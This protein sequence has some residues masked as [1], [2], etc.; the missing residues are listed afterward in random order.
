MK[1]LRALKT[2]G[3]LTFVSLL[4][5]FSSAP[6]IHASEGVVR[7]E[8]MF[9]LKLELNGAFL[10]D[11]DGFLWIGSVS[12]LFR[13][14]GYELK[15]YKAGPDSLSGNWIMSVAE[16]KDGVIWI[17][18]KGGGVTGY[19]KKT[20]IFTHYKH[21]PNDKNSLSINSLPYTNQT[22]LADRSGTLWIGTQGGGLNKFDKKTNTF[23]HYRHDPNHKNS[24]SND[25]VNAVIEDREGMLWIGTEEGGLNR[26]D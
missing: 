8:K 11:K 4:T 3:M 10:R 22:I 6:V 19:D 23:T 1:T 15:S 2:I 14:D 7:F 12:G 5:L 24:L 21:D 18:T 16:D 13:Y 17:G 9:N 26:F 25:K 20:G